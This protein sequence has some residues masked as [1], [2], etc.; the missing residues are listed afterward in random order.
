[1][2]LRLGN[3]DRSV[4]VLQASSLLLN[5]F[6]NAAAAYSLRGL[7]WLGDPVIRVRRSSDSTEQDFTAAQINDGSLLSFVGSGDGLVTTWYDQSGNGND[8][9]QTTASEQP[10]IVDAG[11]LVTE[12]G[13]AALNFDGSDDRLDLGTNFIALQ[14]EPTKWLFATFKDNRSNPG[15]VFGISRG[16]QSRYTLRARPAD[17]IEFVASDS[18]NPVGFAY[19]DNQVLVTGELSGSTQAIYKNGVL[20]DTDERGATSTDANVANIG[21]FAGGSQLLNGLV[22]ELIFYPSDQSANRAA[23]ES[24]INNYYGIY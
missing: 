15:R 18:F 23:I 7:R 1:M 11:V 22:H 10:K 16:G 20:E 8:A 9:T 17:G 6:P 14:Q 13:K 12:N 2:T 24:N 19:T 21:A 3:S 5:L 4:G